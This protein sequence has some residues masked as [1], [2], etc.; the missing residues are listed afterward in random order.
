M[1]DPQRQRTTE[2]VKN[3]ALGYGATILSILSFVV[4]LLL[5]IFIVRLASGIQQQTS[6][7]AAQ[8]NIESY[9]TSTATT[10]SA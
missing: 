2:L 7:P 10:R 3:A 5:I 9:S 4:I 8:K 1:Q 6:V